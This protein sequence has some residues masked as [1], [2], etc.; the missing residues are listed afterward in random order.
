MGLID[1]LIVI[2]PVMIVLGIGFYSRRYIRGVVDFLA[3]GRV[4]GRYV[5]CV[6]DMANAL[7]IIG[8]VAYIEV[9]YKAGFALGFWTKILG[10]LSI[11]W[12]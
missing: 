12:P 10:P 2:I 3:A 11:F 1:W 9:H 5:I 8:L 7:S 6:G 4:C